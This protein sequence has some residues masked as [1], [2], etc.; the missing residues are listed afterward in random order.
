MLRLRLEFTVLSEWMKKPQ[1]D[2]VALTITQLG[3]VRHR[4]GDVFLWQLF[5]DGLHA[6]RLSTCQSS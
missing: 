3:E 6:G 4:F 2:K 1:S 5:S